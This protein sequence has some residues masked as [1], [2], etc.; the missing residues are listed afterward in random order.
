MSKL[1]ANIFSIATAL[2]YLWS[3]VVK[4][5]KVDYFDFLCKKIEI[6]VWIRCYG[7]CLQL[8]G[9]WNFFIYIQFLPLK[10]VFFWTK[11]R[12]NIYGSFFHSFCAT[13]LN[14]V[15]KNNGR[16]MVFCY[17]NYSDLLWEKKCSSDRE[18][19]VKFK[20]EGWEFA[21]FLRSLEQFIQTVKGQ[22][23]FW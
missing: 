9:F 17:Q 14:F 11:S 13:D 6:L 23:N 5:V 21:R 12:K 18:K 16:T 15:N 22:N 20:A 8:L 2:N 7:N 1:S 19:L 3:S 4:V 10:L